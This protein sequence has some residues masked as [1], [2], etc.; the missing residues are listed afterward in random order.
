MNLLIVIPRKLRNIYYFRISWWKRSSE[1]QLNCQH[2]G[3]ILLVDR[4]EERH[5]SEYKHLQIMSSILPN[6][7]YTQPMHLEIPQVPFVSC[8]KDSIGQLPTTSKGNRF[9]LTCIC[10]LT[11]YLITVPL[12]LK[13]ADSVSMVYITEILPKTSCSK[14]ILQDNGTKFKSKQ[15]MSILCTKWI[16]SNPYYPRGNSRMENIHN[17]LKRTMTKFIHGSQLKWDDA[18]PLVTYCYNIASSVDDL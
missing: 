2:H 4:N 17:F 14:F 6:K 16:Y 12:T 5:P 1:N 15:I 9:T 3:E 18:L 10:L 7:V 8:A 13:M 11:S